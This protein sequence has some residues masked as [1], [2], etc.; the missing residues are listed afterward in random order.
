MDKHVM[1]HLVLTDNDALA[2]QKMIDNFY[3]ISYSTDFSALVSA[4]YKQRI[5]RVAHKLQEKALIF[6]S[7]LDDR[8][9]E[10]M[11]IAYLA[12]FEEKYPGAHIDDILFTSE[13]TFGFV[14]FTDGGDIYN[15]E[16]S[17]TVYQQILDSHHYLL[18]KN[19]CYFIDHNWALDLLNQQTPPTETT[20]TIEVHYGSHYFA[21]TEPATTNMNLCSCQKQSIE[22]RIKMFMQHYQYLDNDSPKESLLLR[23]LGLPAYFQQ[24][25]ETSKLSYGEKW[26]SLLTYQ[27]K[28]CQICNTQ[29]NPAILSDDFKKQWGLYINNR[30]FHYGIDDLEQGGIYFII[31]ALSPAQRSLLCPTKTELATELQAFYYELDRLYALP[32]A[33]FAVLL[34]HRNKAKLLRERQLP[35]SRDLWASLRFDEAFIKALNT[36]MHQRFITARNLIREELKSMLPTYKT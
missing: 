3:L 16:F 14:I 32:Q 7:A 30:Y 18:E 25:I 2:C 28:L 35:S 19:D 12:E 20:A 21:F 8:I 36:A 5:V 33:E 9:L 10:L 15:T 34:Y 23:F 31:D 13:P 6:D 29:N 11:K 1:I 27:T 26:L 4:G 17:E 24:K 22:N